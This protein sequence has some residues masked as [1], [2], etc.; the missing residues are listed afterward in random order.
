MNN[1]HAL[2]TFCFD[3]D[4]TLCKTNGCDYD[5][6]QPYIERI[7][8]VNKLYNEGHTIF[9]DSARGSGTGIYWTTKTKKQLDSWGLKYHKVRCGRKFAADIYVDDKAF[10]SED[11]F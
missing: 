1:P 10:N 4:D 6:S 9:I 3:L 8:L 11:Y 5:N 7:N 2:K